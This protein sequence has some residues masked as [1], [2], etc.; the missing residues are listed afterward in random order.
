MVPKK[1][2]LSFKDA[3]SDKV[4]HVSLEKSSKLFVVNFAY[5][6]RGG[7]L[8]EGTKTPKPVAYDKA[9]K[10]YDKLVKSKTDK[11]YKQSKVKSSPKTT[12]VKNEAAKKSKA[13][14]IKKKKSSVK[15]KSKTT[16]SD[17]QVSK[18]SRL[19]LS[20]DHANTKLALRILE[21]STFPK[22]LI[23][24][25][26][27]VYRITVDDTIRELTK[28][29]IDKYG[30][31][32]LVKKSKSNLSFRTYEDEVATNIRRLTRDNELDG[33]KIAKA[34]YKYYDIGIHYLLDEVTKEEQVEL[35][36]PYINGTVFRMSKF[37]LRNF[38]TAL[39]H[40]PF[41]TEIDLS[42]NLIQT[43]P[44]EIEKMVNLKILNLSKND[45]K[46]LPKTIGNLKN[47]EI[48]NWS[49]NYYLKNGNIPS[50]A[51]DLPLKKIKLAVKQLYNNKGI[52]PDFLKYKNLTE[53]IIYGSFKEDIII[54]GKPVQLDLITI[55]RDVLKNGQIAFAGSHLIN[56]GSSEDKMLVLNTIYDKK[57]KT[58]DVSKMRCKDIPVEITN[59]DV[60]HLVCEKSDMGVRVL[61]AYLEHFSTCLE[62]IVFK[63][64]K[65][66]K[67]EIIPDLS[68]FKK[69]KSINLNY[70]NTKEIINLSSLKHL[71]ELN[72][73]QTEF[74]VFPEGL[75][76]VKSLKKLKLTFST[77]ITGEKN[78]TKRNM[79][80]GD[81]YEDAMEKCSKF[82]QLSKLEILSIG[83]STATIGEEDLRSFLPKKCTLNFF[84]K[85]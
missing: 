29:I 65:G 11:G 85:V 77:S 54:K 17:E 71:E 75:F 21:N 26:F 4:Y 24:E 61:E 46:R 33:L 19:L 42:D 18:V 50:T 3:K 1:I 56:F 47:L 7:N 23:T 58:M 66:K 63:E 8:K 16:L 83:L 45:L 57:T 9:L 68:T 82:K 52:N 80:K 43:I 81:R 70:S 59:F 37:R 69:L 13:T 79:K 67:A 49:Y 15:A 36:K 74:K 12:K 62:T 27:L 31:L 51:Y 48:L 53:V 6:K 10:I 64:C 76:D 60:S 32:D 44:P 55:S 5:G 38:P 84:D 35:L 78:V 39:I 14:P 25:I 40:F 2:Q 72:L 28:N 22:E 20:R 41:L 34:L 73:Y 30:S